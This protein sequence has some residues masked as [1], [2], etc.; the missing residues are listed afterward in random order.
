MMII[1]PV[2][3]VVPARLVLPVEEV[4]HCHQNSFN[5]N[6]GEERDPANGAIAEHRA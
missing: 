4:F 2:A 1:A 5:T 6:V 3:I